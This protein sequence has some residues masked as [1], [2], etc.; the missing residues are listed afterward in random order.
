MKTQLPLSISTIAEA[1]VFLTNLFNNGE[2]FH[3]EDDAHTVAWQGAEPSADECDQLNKL[4]NDIYALPGNNN[5][6][7]MSFDPCGFI[8]SLDKDYQKLQHMTIQ[9]KEKSVYGK[10]LIYPFDETAKKFAALLN[11]KSF[12]QFHLTGIKALGYDIINVTPK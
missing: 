6:Q 9:I 8:L 5:S 7:D 2:V 12:N 10:I 1:Q 3:P 11:I 4:M